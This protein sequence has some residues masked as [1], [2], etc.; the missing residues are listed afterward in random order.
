VKRSGSTGG[1]TDGDKLIAAMK[2]HAFK[3]VS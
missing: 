2:G 1:A 3:S